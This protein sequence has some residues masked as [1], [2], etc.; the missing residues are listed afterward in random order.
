[1]PQFMFVYRGDHEDMTH[2]SPD[3]MQQ[4]LQRWLDWIRRGTD[5]GWM[6][7]GGDS[8][9]PG[10]AIVSPDL[11]VTKGTLTES[12]KLVRGY[13]LVEASDL[14][15]AIQ[16]AQGSP[17]PNSGGTVEVREVAPFGKQDE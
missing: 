7:D 15:N 14:T 13:S 17:L 9:M 5:A 10:G 11:I 1:M 8:L 16:L 4:L 12:K 6:L 2:A 3:Q